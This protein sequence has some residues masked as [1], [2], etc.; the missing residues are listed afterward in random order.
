MTITGRTWVAALE[1]DGRI[2]EVEL[3]PEDF[4]LPVHPLEAILGGTP[5]ENA[6]ALRGL[7]DGEKSAYRDAVL[8]NAAAALVVAGH[9]AELHE[10][11]AQAAESIDSGEARR[12]LA[13]LATVTTE[14]AA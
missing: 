11:V 7:L 1:E 12:R 5:Q 13:I 14:E 3:H 6:R 9:A 4:G 2:R 8:L 10:G